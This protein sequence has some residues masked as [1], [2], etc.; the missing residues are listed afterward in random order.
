[1]KAWAENWCYTF[2]LALVCPKQLKPVKNSGDNEKQ[3]IGS[4]LYKTKME[5]VMVEVAAEVMV[6]IM[7][8]K[9]NSNDDFKLYLWQKQ[10]LN[11]EEF[12]YQ[13]LE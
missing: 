8:L 1:M 3:L 11:F 7:A 12:F 5:V 10:K 13:V 9:L 4:K 2:K 6:V